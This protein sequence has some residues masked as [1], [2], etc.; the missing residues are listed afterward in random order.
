M[1][2]HLHREYEQPG[3]TD[4]GAVK[5]GRV[6]LVSPCTAGQTFHFLTATV[7]APGTNFTGYFCVNAA[8]SGTYVQSGGAHGTGMIL[9]SGSA[10]WISASGS[11]LALL[12]QKS[13]HHQHLH[14]DG[15][16]AH[17][18]GDVTLT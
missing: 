12:G 15:A 2:R 16:A 9:T 1:G 6:T 13:L 7:K 8:G 11:G 17:E 18:D 10:T 14:R 3:A 4:N 5:R